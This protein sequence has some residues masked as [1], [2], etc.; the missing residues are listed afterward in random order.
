VHPIAAL[1]YP[2]ES[3]DVPETQAGHEQQPIP[4]TLLTAIAANG[5]RL[6][7]L[8]LDWWRIDIPSLQHLLRASPKLRI[9]RMAVYAPVT[10]VVG[11]ICQRHCDIR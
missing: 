1:P 11:Y 9:L 10:K 6:E 5:S 7:D 3:V 4:E 2:P 8:G